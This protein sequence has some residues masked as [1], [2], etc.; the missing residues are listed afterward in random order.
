LGYKLSI[1]LWVLD[2][3]NVQ[4][5]LLT[6]ELFKIATNTV[7]FSA[8]TTNDNAWA[9]GVDVDTNAIASSL[10]LHASNTGSLHALSHQFADGHIFGDV[11]AVT[12]AY[13]R[14]VGKPTRPELGSD[15]KPEAMRVNFL[16]H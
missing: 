16:A 5:D 12:L 4:L 2:L 10:D 9:C 7:G 8:T 14:T 13:S 3:K 11:V 1:N 15:S 6:S